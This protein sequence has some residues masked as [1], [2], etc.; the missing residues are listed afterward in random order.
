M[1]AEDICGSE[2]APWDLKSLCYLRRQLPLSGTFGSS[3]T[4]DSIV[5]S[6]R[7][8]CFPVEHFDVS[9]MVITFLIPLSS[10]RIFL[11]G[12]SSASRLRT[13]RPFCSYI[14]AHCSTR[15]MK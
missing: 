15:S 6:I 14:E 5:S 9:A 8:T 11:A 2:M 13:R 12:I 3:S 7:Q 10:V 4:L 1:L